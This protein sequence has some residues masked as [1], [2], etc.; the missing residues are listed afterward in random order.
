MQDAGGKLNKTVGLACNVP[1]RFSEITL[2][3]QVHV[4]SKAPFQVLLGRPLD[5]LGKSL[6]KNFANGDQEITLTDPNSGKRVTVP[7]FPRGAKG[8]RLSF[9]VSRYN[10][11]KEKS[12]FEQE[13]RPEKTED[14]VEKGNFQSSTICL[15][16]KE[17]K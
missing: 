1:F 14:G 13:S 7:T 17:R 15:V 11:P 9:D 8:R 12:L 6:V 4:Q 3:L 10:V 2:Y 16:N 5:V